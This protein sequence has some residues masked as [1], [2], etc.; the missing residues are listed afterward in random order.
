MKPRSSIF[1]GILLLIF[2][3]VL[4]ATRSHTSAR[5]PKTQS[6]AR[7]SEGNTSA[8]SPPSP[9]EVPPVQSE[10]TKSVSVNICGIGSVSLAANA[11]APDRY[12]EDRS[13]TAETQWKQALLDSDDTRARALGLALRFK[14]SGVD[15][16]QITQDEARD[17]LVQLA[18]GTAD[19]A[20][21]AIGLEACRAVATSPPDAAC[22][23][24]SPQGWA[25][26]D[27]KNA[28]PWLMMMS[29]ATEMHDGKSVEDDLFRQAALAQTVTSY[30]EAMYGFAQKDRPTDMARL[31][32]SYAS[33]DLISELLSWP[34]IPMRPLIDHCSVEA[35][36]DAYTRSQCSAI[37]DLLMNKGNTIIYLTTG[38]VLGQ[39]AGE[40]ASRLQAAEDLKRAFGAELTQQAPPTWNCESVHWLNEYADSF[41][42]GGEL[43]AL[44]DA[45]ARGDGSMGAIVS[46]EDSFAARRRDSSVLK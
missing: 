17:E 11:D 21:Y 24:L 31:E 8:N 45:L 5:V 46:R 7:T 2:V 34:I 33:M 14:G 39:R 27:P 19:P 6:L 28:A 23:Q 44:R 29:D 26:I 43:G 25:R 42:R 12:V 40:P 16:T 3:A 41:A 1:L 30:A 32:Q 18:V 20:V 10:G 38:W 13:K 22:R 36:Q 37:A 9:H 4:L 35:M 15:T